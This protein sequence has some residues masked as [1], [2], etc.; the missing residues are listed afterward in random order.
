MI[1]NLEY[2][3]IPGFDSKR[4]N[5]KVAK[6]PPLHEDLFSKKFPRNG[7]QKETVHLN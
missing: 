2:G 6:I 5:L 7:S 1:A 3:L 4:L